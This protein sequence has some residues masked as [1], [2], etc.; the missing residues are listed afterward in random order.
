MELLEFNLTSIV[1]LL[2]FVLL[3]FFLYKFMYKPY[4]DATAER[5]NKIKSELESAE[6]IKLQA[7]EMKNDAQIKLEEVNT[8]AAKIIENAKKTSE[9]I[10]IE[11]REKARNQVERMLK[12]ASEEIET[13][14]LDA[15]SKLQ[16][17]AVG[18]A[19][20]MASKL[21]EKQM[22]EKTQRDFLKNMLSTLKEGE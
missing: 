11:E 21:I 6:N 17:E 9:K 2:Q 8:Q 15:V 12:S 4:L 14:K 5:R 16:Q 18:L 3:A 10:L 19:V 1:M 20:L 22:D 7:I 13:M